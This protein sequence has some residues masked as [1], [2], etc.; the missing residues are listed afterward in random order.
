MSHIEFLGPPGAG[1]SSIYQKV[2][3]S[4]NIYG[5]VD[6]DAIRR[7]L[8]NYICTKYNSI[9]NLLPEYIQNLCEDYY[10]KHKIK[11]KV[12]SEF[13][14]Q[15]PEYIDILRDI[16]TD[17]DYEP[18]GLFRM[19][20][21]CA[22]EYQLGFSTVENEEIL[23]LDEGFAQRAVALMWRFCSH[24]FNLAEYYDSIPTPKLLI[25]VC[26][27]AKECVR[28]QVERNRLTIAK[29]WT[30][31]DLLAAQKEIIQI[32]RKVREQAKNHT[33]VITIRNTGSVDSAVD[34]VISEINSA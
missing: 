7:Y 15:H 28:R 22:E 29:D 2:I 34:D 17:A 3:K 31:A 20:K 4:E 6:N 14:Y 13:L 21:I 11:S 23:C 27:P 16:L 9:Y 32:C 18:E 25:Y 24:S 8:L 19:Y 5:G 33:K 1:K 10:I 26:V 30:S 12:F